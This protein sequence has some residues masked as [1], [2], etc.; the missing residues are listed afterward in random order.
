LT[1]DHG[2]SSPPVGSADFVLARHKQVPAVNEG[3]LL[4]EDGR[5]YAEVETTDL[6]CENAP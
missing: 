4:F 1:T 3:N 5:V 6:A 2:V